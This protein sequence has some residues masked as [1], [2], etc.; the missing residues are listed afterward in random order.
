[1]FDRIAIAA[2]K[3]N[4]LM[5]DLRGR[6]PNRSKGAHGDGQFPVMFGHQHFVCRFDILS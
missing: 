2:I 1:M 4:F 6:P 3:G 5:I